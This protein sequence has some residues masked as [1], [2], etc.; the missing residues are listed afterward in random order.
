MAEVAPQQVDQEARVLAVE[1]LVQTPIL[2]QLGHVRRIGSRLG[3]HL[4]RVAGEPHQSEDNTGQEPQGNE[5]VQNACQYEGPHGL[6][7]SPPR[8]PRA[9]GRARAGYPSSGAPPRLPAARWGR[10]RAQR[11]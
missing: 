7:P 8:S 6:T 3:L 9:M 2:T 1:R 4:D 11:D 10:R 5:A